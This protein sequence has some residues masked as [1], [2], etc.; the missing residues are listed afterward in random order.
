MASSTQNWLFALVL[1]FTGLIV[2]V[3]LFGM[4]NSFPNNE[5]TT[6]GTGGMYGELTNTANESQGYAGEGSI[7]WS[8]TFKFVWSFFGWNLYVNEGEV[9]MQY[10]WVLR[11]F[12]VYLPFI[13]LIITLFYSTVLSGGH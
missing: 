6:T 9:I 12:L 1:Y 4:A 8:E 13:A 11:I 10:L 5:V 3:S 7:S 2:V